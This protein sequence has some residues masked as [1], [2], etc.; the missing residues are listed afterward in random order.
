MDTVD[1]E[2]LR[3][4]A[5]L[6]SLS[7]AAKARGVSVS[8]V[9]RRLDALEAVLGVRVLERSAKGVR[10]TRDG[11][12]IASLAQPALEAVAAI[13]RAAAA[14]KQDGERKT[15]RVSATEFVVTEVLAPQ[16]AM[17][18]IKAPDV[19]LELLSE[20]AVVSLA[21]RDADI[22]VRMTRP[23]GNSLFARALPAI[24]LGAFVAPALREKL[25]LEADWKLPLLTYD[26][27]Y[28]R[29]PEHK[30]VEHVGRP[31][32]IVVRTSS[33]GALLQAAVAGGGAALLPTA[34]ARRAGLVEIE[35]MSKQFSR[36]PWITVHKDLRRLTHIRA[37]MGWIA[38]SFG[39]ALR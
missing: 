19:T 17:L 35:A 18:Q 4:V 21:E 9:S 1:L 39:H 20:A 23:S 31:T 27:S 5:E 11:R 33:T 28:G 8:T 13:G 6:G 7:A 29:L 16:I 38:G 26:D 36:T 37:T 22:A 14:L 30:W 15:V 10:L 24:E 34:F 25:Q 32:E 2:W 3:S 12:R